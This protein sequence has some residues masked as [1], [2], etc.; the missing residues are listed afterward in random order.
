[1]VAGSLAIDRTPIHP[2][3]PPPQIIS[4][5]MLSQ[6]SRCPSVLSNSTSHCSGSPWTPPC[7]GRSRRCPRPASRL[8]S[9]MG[10]PQTR[11]G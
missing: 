1:M 2:T 7:C 10:A 6:T 8:L 5:P 9:S 11:E 4:T 3:P